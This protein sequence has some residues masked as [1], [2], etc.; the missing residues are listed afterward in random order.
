M[1]KK[2]SLLVVTM[3]VALSASAQFEQG[4]TYISASFSGL[5]FGYNGTSE[6][7]VGLQAKGGYFVEDNLL[8]LGSLGYN[9]IG[10]D[11][12]PDRISLGL[13]TPFE[14]TLMEI[15]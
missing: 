4:K 7:N 14:W 8:V 11:D 5:D 15:V 10:A 12:T 9:H 2:I 6:L 13:H 1:I 3:M